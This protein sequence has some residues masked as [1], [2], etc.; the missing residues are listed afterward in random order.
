[1][2]NVPYVSAEMLLHQQW[3]GFVSK[4]ASHEQCFR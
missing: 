3:K 4:S 2:K 1:M